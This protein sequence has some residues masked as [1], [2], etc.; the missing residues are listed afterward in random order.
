MG[1]IGGNSNKMEISLLLSM[2]K[3]QQIYLESLFFYLFTVQSQNTTQ[4][5][6][7]SALIIVNQTETAGK[8]HKFHR[9]VQVTHLN[10]PLSG[11]HSCSSPPSPLLLYK[12]TLQEGKTPKKT[13]KVLSISIV[14]Q[15]TNKAN[16]SLQQT[17]TFKVKTQI[18]PL[19]QNK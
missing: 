19:L 11:L 18:T 9:F 3:F 12:S 15:I 16:T 10:S 7:V 2:A 6:S 8:I 1:L 5:L 14:L 13:S 17:L 4:F